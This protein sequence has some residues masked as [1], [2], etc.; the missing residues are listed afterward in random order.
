MLN[1]NT[2]SLFKVQTILTEISTSENTL[3]NKFTDIRGQYFIKG[4]GK[5]VFLAHLKTPIN[6]PKYH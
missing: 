2:D 1:I 3:D 4:K 6:F 5:N